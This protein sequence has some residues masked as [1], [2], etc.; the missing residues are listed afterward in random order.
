MHIP[1][2]LHA[3]FGRQLALAAVCGASLL[4]A[5]ILQAATYTWDPGSDRSDAAGSGSWNTITAAWDNGT[6][7]VPWTNGANTA[8]FNGTDGTYAVTVANGI[9]A[10]DLVINSSGYTLQGASATAAGSLT[11][12]GASFFSQL[13]VATGKTLT[14]GAN[15][16]VTPSSGSGTN[17]NS[18]NSSY[19]GTINVANGGTLAFANGPATTQL[20]GALVVGTNGTVGN[21]VAI[22]AIN[23]GSL[24]MNG[25]GSTFT[26]RGIGLTNS[27]VTINQGTFSP[28]GGMSTSLTNS[29]INLNSGGVFVL[30]Y[31]TGIDANS[32]INFNGGSFQ[33]STY[34]GLAGTQNGKFVVQAGGAKFDASNNLSIPVALLHDVNGPAVDGGLTTS[35]YS[36]TLTKAGTYTGGTRVTGGKLTVAS[37]AGLG[38]GDASVLATAVSLTISTG[39]VTPFGTSTASLTLAGGG[40]ANTADVG[41]LDLTSGANI[42]VGG[43]TLGTTSYTSGVF[44]SAAFPEY[45]SGSGTVTVVPEPGSLPLACVM[46][47]LACIGFFARARRG[48]NGMIDGR[49]CTQSRARP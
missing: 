24:T 18:G 11:L 32:V 26:V 9:T 10:G 47:G 19:A 33:S 20:G 36:L 17:I 6:A 35:S 30:G 40:K 48:Q 8:T 13:L 49:T 16:T 5:P 31:V 15:I 27:T 44:T 38:S 29:T 2:A 1:P 39:V 46:G 21:Q 37:N 23:N 41:Y 12:S 7:D 34:G 3:S 14:I 4:A 42:T 28:S 22:A 45:I 25:A 43:L